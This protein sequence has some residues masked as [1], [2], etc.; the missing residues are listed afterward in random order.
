MLAEIT[1]R[2]DDTINNRCLALYDAAVLNRVRED[3]LD[4]FVYFFDR[5]GAILAA[6]YGY[7]P[8]ESRWIKEKKLI[9]HDFEIIRFHYLL[10]NALAACGHTLRRWE[11]WRDDLHHFHDPSSKVDFIPDA[12]LWID[13]ERRPSLLEVV[14]ANLRS[15]K[16]NGISD[17][18][19]KL[20]AYDKMDLERVFVVM[21]TQQRAERFLENMEALLNRLDHPK[22][23]WVSYE[24]IYHEDILGKIRF[25]PKDVRTGKEYSILRPES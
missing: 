23:I 25:T 21:P 17:L 7:L 13:D 11:Q 22:R 19:L 3:R 9:K 15:S 12:Q 8:D 2:K 4:P 5:K 10:K 6:Q 18:A 16:T 20:L 24:D 1:G 14:N